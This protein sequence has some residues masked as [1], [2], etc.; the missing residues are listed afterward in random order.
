MANEPGPGGTLATAAVD[1]LLGPQRAE[2]LHDAQLLIAACRDLI[3]ETGGVDPPVS[4]ILK[5]AGLGSR[6]FYRLFPSKHDLLMAVLEAGT[7]ALQASIRS[8]LAD[9]PDPAA[10][11]HAWI[12]TFVDHTTTTPA[13]GTA[14]LILDAPRFSAIFPDASAA[15]ERRIITPLHEALDGLRGDVDTEANLAD[16]TVVYDIVASAVVRALARTQ[17]IA[18]PVRAHLHTCTTRIIEREHSGTS[19]A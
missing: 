7:E 3:T 16:A 19:P 17:P 15:L 4:L 2:Y 6:A 18:D 9:V 10:R 8:R 12:D 5:R 11:I 14:S 13:D 1:R